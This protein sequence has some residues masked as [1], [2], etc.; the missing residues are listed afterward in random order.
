MTDIIHNIKATGG[1]LIHRLLGGIFGDDT[2]NKIEDAFT[3]GVHHIISGLAPAALDIVTVVAQG[4]L[5][6]GGGTIDDIIKATLEAAKPELEK[7]GHIV[8][9]DLLHT[10]TRIVV[11]GLQAASAPATGA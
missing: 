7:Q 11:T 4:A 3:A 6:A 9:Q 2:A 1:S 8:E 10:A 5:A